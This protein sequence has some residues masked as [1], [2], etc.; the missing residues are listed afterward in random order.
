MAERVAVIGAGIVGLA[1]AWQEARHGAQV[2][3]FER[4]RSALGA[5]I[6]NFGMV[7]P[8]GQPNGPLHR[9]A[10]RSRELWSDFIAE[11][12]VWCDPCGSLHLACQADELDVLQEF[13]ALAPELGY[14]CHLLGADEIERRWPTV[15][16]AALLGGLWSPTEMCVN[17]RQVI[18]KAPGWL[19][20]RWGVDLQF[21]TC[22]KEIEVPKLRAT[23]GREWY[24]DR[25][26]VATGVDC[27]D[28]YPEVWRASRLGRCKL[29][30]MRTVVQPPGWRLGTLLASGLTLRH[31]AA[32]R[33]CSSLSKL[34]A[35]ISTESPDLDRFGIHVM[36]AQ[37]AE[38]TIVIGDSHEYDDEIGPFDKES[39]NDLILVEL[40][41]FLRLPDWS[42]AERWHGVYA[43]LTDEIQFVRRP[44]PGVTIVIATGGA[45][46]TM[47]F[48]LAEFMVRQQLQKDADPSVETAAALPGL[49]T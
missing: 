42:I 26:T 37:D 34:R 20:D 32:F 7:W 4:D 18:A 21:G 46:M 8:I 1:H 35:R 47:S 16:N 28:L 11:T 31:Y 25:V 15:H 41:R 36:A 49:A 22:V 5:S 14:D 9:V 38:G 44:S 6:R 23:D 19:R 40:Q 12:G 33:V 30:M 10:M 43:T 29:Q 3:L 24:F 2:T 48:G 45:G 13:A 27:E 39:I 17:P